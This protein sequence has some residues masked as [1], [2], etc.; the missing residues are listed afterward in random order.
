MRVAV[1]GCGNVSDRYLANVAPFA[2]L[3]VVAC[4]DV[5]VARARDL[6]G[7]HGVALAATPAEVLDHP[8]VDLV[9]NLTPP[10]SHAEV[11]LSALDRGK[12]VYTE[13]PLGASLAEGRQILARARERGLEVGSAP[14]TFMGAGTA[15]CARLIRDGAIGTPVSISGA[16]MNAGPERFHPEPEFLYRD[17][18]GPL[19]DI[20]PYFVTAMV[21]L[22]GPVARV[23]ALGTRSA[24][25][26]RILAGPRAGAAFAVETETHVMSLLK[27]AGG[28]VAT[29][30]TSFDVVATRTPPLE[31]HG[32]EGSLVA[33]EANSWGGPVLL[34][35]RGESDFTEVL[36]A[37]RPEDGFMGMGLVDMARALRQGRPVTAGGDRA[38]HVLEVLTAV[39]SSARAGGQLTEI[40]PVMLASPDTTPSSTERA[41]LAS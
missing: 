22:L 13:K 19:F 12:H 11:S 34:M 18:A 31:I 8:G 10:R 1:V 2:D 25:E 41:G 23:S 5:D 28:G 24:D 36:P 39:A 38:L 16:V 32:T 35:R 17:G 4:A 27:F 14:D 37:A 3:E 29:L 6:A 21:A 26:R 40:T 33:A 20:G 30:V 9:L 7:R 15:L